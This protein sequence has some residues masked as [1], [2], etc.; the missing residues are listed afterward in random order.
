[1]TRDQAVA[2]IKRQLAFK[3]TL[4]TEIVEELQ[5]A[6]I[7]L[8]QRPTK[9]WFLLSEQSTTLTE[10][11]EDRV[12]VPPDFLEEHEEGALEFV[13]ADTTRKPIR[14]VKEDW[15]LLKTNYADT[16]PGEPAAYA[17]VGSYFAC[18]L[19]RMLFTRFG[20]SISRRASF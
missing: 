12:L 11:N 7:D 19:S 13:P 9:P 3:Q 4:D 10:I 6:Q 16:A 5:D 14:L 2:R 15:D 8:E 20:S 1:M 18:C 17:L